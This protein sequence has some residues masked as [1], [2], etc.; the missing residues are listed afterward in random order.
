MNDDDVNTLY[1][2]FNILS[3]SLKT[4]D[5][6]PLRIYVNKIEHRTP[7]RIFQKILSSTSTPKRIKL[8]GSC[9][10]LLSIL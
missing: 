4:T 2:I 5:N 10:H 1:S 8:F 3:I 9:G 6:P 7:F